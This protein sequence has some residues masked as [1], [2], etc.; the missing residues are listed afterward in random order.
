MYIKLGEN[1]CDFSD[2]LVLRYFP[3]T[4]SFWGRHIQGCIHG[5]NMTLET[6]RISHLFIAII[7]LG[8]QGYGDGINTDRKSLDGNN[9][10]TSTTT[11]SALQ[12]DLVANTTKEDDN[13]GTFGTILWLL[14]FFNSIFTVEF[15]T[16]YHYL[17]TSQTD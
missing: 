12:R 8:I 15:S 13:N 9:A 4:F 1:R 7:W 6:V 17:T 5:K 10:T 16:I 14:A 11:S 3:Y 2:S